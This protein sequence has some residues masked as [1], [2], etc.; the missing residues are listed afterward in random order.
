[1]IYC[2]R[3]KVNKK[4]NMSNCV[5]LRRKNGPG[6]WDVVGAWGVGARTIIKQLKEKN[7]KSIA[8]NGRV[9]YYNFKDFK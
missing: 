8:N 6:Q 2:F 4:D 3:V 5:E 7:G 9:W 1:M